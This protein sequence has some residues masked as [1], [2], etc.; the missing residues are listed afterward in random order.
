MALLHCWFDDFWLLQISFVGFRDG[1]DLQLLQT[2]SQKFKFKKLKLQCTPNGK[3]KRKELL[4]KQKSELFVVAG[5][6][7]NWAQW[8]HWEPGGGCPGLCFATSLLPLNCQKQDVWDSVGLGEGNG[9]GE[10][11]WRKSV[12]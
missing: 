9:L 10:K 8:S 7:Q 4:W 3:S 12:L 11:E 2:L 6:G 5:A 1:F